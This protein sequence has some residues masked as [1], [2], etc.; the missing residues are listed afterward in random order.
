MD[1]SFES[2]APGDSEPSDEPPPML[3]PIRPVPSVPTPEDVPTESLARAA[4]PEE[5]EPQ[6]PHAALEYFRAQ[7]ET[8]AAE[9]AGGRLNRTQFHAIYQHYSERRIIIERLLQRDPESDAWKQVAQ[10]G[11]TTFLRAHFEARPVFY[12]VFGHKLPRPLN[13]G[14]QRSPK[15]VEQIGKLL[16]T[17]WNLQTPPESGLA[18]KAVGDGQWLVLAMGKFGITF[19]VFSLQ[20]SAAQT[21]R[22]RD[23]HTDFERANRRLLE[24]GSANPSRMVFPQRSLIP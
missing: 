13:I 17:L 2:D 24:R 8:I 10:P 15:L 16:R 23:L 19:V 21:N 3:S 22:V 9:F 4:P 11:H 14:G 20:P 12:A 18:R 5:R 1:D 7:M 6:D